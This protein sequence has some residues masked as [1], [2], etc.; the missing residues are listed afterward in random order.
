MVLKT[1]LYIKKKNKIKNKKKIKKKK[2]MQIRNPAHSTCRMSCTEILSCFFIGF[3]QTLKT[4]MAL[5]VKS[6]CLGLYYN[7][8]RD[9]GNKELPNLTKITLIKKHPRNACIF[10]HCSFPLIYSVNNYSSSFVK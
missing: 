6:C 10:V 2:T 9:D 4:Q 3:W 7:I 5:L 8:Y 1:Q